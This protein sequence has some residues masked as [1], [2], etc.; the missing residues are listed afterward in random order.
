MK[1]FIF[2][3]LTVVGVAYCA[4][5]PTQ[6]LQDPEGKNYSRLSIMRDIGVQEPVRLA[7]TAFADQTLDTN[8]WTATLASSGTAIVSNGTLVLRNGLSP[9]GGVKVAARRVGRYVPGQ[10]NF[11]HG[12][13]LV[14]D[15]GVDGNV[16]AWGATDASC[17]NGTGFRLD[18]TNFFLT[19]VKNGVASYISNSQ[20]NGGNTFTLD[21]NYNTYEV[22]YTNKKVQWFINDKIM[23]SETITNS[24][25][26]S[27]LHLGT[28]AYNT[29]NASTSSNTT[30]I[31]MSS[32]IY[33]FGSLRTENAYKYM[34]N[35]ANN[36][37]IGPGVLHNL[38]VNQATATTATIYDSTNAAG[39]IIGILDLNKTSITPMPYDCPFQNGLT[40]D[41]SG[42]SNI[43]VTY[44]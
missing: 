15:A 41:L 18:G 26:T 16:R 35:G 1:K 3:L 28:C 42:P 4:Y 23:H 19:T 8:F 33:R 10:E 24:S 29:N 7:G 31:A 25:W 17:Q 20:W 21:Q 32:S 2:I 40:V 43:T 9:T 44:E 12:V 37:K 38:L 5:M 22:H 27:T 14:G 13:I 39:L 34:T 30:L 6:S 36:L 11:F